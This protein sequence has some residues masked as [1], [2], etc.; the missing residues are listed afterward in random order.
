MTAPVRLLTDAQIA[1]RVCERVF[2]GRHNALMQHREISDQ[3]LHAHAHPDTVEAIARHLRE[4]DKANG[5]TFTVYGKSQVSTVGARV[6][7]LP[8]QP[9]ETVPYGDARVDIA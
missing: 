6:Y 3:D 9:D 4:L 1:E 5:R 2:R 8:L 7:G